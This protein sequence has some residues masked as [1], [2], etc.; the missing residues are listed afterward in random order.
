MTSQ[1]QPEPLRY[2]DAGAYLPSDAYAR[3]PTSVTVVAIIG[4]VL[5]ALGLLCRPASLLV[6]AVKLPVQNPVVDA[7]RNDSFILGW[8]VIGVATEWV[9]S[10]LLL[11]SSVG[12]LGLRE[13]ARTGMLAYA[14][15]KLVMMV[16]SQVI[17]ILVVNPTLAPAMKQVAEQQP[18]AFQASP[19]TSAIVMTVWTLWLPLLILWVYT[20][21]MV[22]EAFA[23]G[24]APTGATI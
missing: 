21:P 22:K 4:I 17:G 10:L 23:R 2:T 19:T 11:L 8:M 20:R 5:G 24:P 9:I 3:R 7:M 6:F 14:P 15:L 18:S 13:W 16:I 12:S 1:P